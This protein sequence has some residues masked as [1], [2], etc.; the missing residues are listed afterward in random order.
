MAVALCSL[1]GVFMSFP[2]PV[3]GTSPALGILTI[4]SH[5]TGQ[6]TLFYGTVVR[7]ITNF[8][9]FLTL[10]KMVLKLE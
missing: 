4:L 3:F 6:A 2:G 7:I 5:S 10:M 8:V 9:L 1:G